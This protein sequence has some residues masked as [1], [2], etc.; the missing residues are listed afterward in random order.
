M[1]DNLVQVKS[2]ITFLLSSISS[3]GPAFGRVIRPSKLMTR[4]Q[5]LGERKLGKRRIGVTFVGDIGIMVS[6]RAGVIV[7]IA[8]QLAVAALGAMA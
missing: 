3:S 7:A 2:S 1:T 8:L 5:F 6:S 4:V